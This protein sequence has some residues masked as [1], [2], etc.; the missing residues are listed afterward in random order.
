MVHQF[1]WGPETSNIKNKEREEI[2]LGELVG[3]PSFKGA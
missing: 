1:N 3:D 2:N